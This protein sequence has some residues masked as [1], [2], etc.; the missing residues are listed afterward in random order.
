MKKKY[1]TIIG[2]IGLILLAGVSLMI[3]KLSTVYYGYSNVP[4]RCEN[5]QQS[6]FYD[7]QAM[8]DFCE[9]NGFD[10]EITTKA[11]SYGPTSPIYMLNCKPLPEINCY[12]CLID[13]TIKTR[14][15]IG[16][17][18]SVYVSDS[19][20]LTCEPTM[21][22]CYSCDKVVGQISSGLYAGSCPSGTSNLQPNCPAPT[23]TCYQCGFN[24]NVD[25]RVFDISCEY[26]WSQTMP[27]CVNTIECGACVNGDEQIQSFSNSCESGWTEVISSEQKFCDTI[28]FF[29]KYGII[30]LISGGVLILITIILLIPV[31]KK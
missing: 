7:Y 26:G 6:Y 24:N 8:S 28:D 29:G 12:K 23:V 22:T 20:S 11:G 19:N 3:G 9:D 4:M 31:K 27:I 21:V 13:G 15:Y 10:C 1:I 25:Q 17:C 30:L 5:Y 2:L 14:I 18:G 16:E